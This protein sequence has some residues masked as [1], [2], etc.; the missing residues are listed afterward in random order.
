MRLDAIGD[1]ALKKAVGVMAPTQLATPPKT[2]MAEIAHGAVIIIVNKM[3]AGNILMKL[4]AQIL[5]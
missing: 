3:A 1:H 5:L 4:P 2:G